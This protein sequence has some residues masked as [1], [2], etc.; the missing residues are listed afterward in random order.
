LA[1]VVDGGAQTQ[2]TVDQ[3]QHAEDVGKSAILSELPYG[4]AT[5]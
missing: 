4:E 5:V 1:G 2:R 3:G